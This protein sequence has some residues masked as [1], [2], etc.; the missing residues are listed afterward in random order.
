MTKLLSTWRGWLFAIFAAV[1]LTAC[2][3]VADIIAPAEVAVGATVEFKTQLFEEFRDNPPAD[4]QYEWDFGDGA[5]AQGMSASHV[6]AQPGTY[7]VVLSITD[8]ATRRFGQA[9]IS[10]ATIKVVNGTAMVP[11]SVRVYDDQG[12]SV[13]GATVNVAG[14]SALTDASGGALVRPNRPATSPVAIVQ[15]EGFIT[16]SVLVPDASTAGRGVVVWLKPETAPVNIARIEEAQ[17]LVGDTASLTPTVVLPPQALV[18]ATGQPVSGEATVRVS[19]WDITNA[20]DMQAFPGQARADDGTGR[21]VSLISF[22]MLT[23]EF[24]QAGERL[25]LAPGKTAVISMDLPIQTDVE[26]REL[27]VGHKIPLWH[28]N[29][30]RGLWV[31]EGEG[32]VVASET[33]STGLGVSAVVGHFS[34]WNWDVIVPP[35]P[36]IT[37]VARMIRCELPSAEGS[38]TAIAANDVCLVNISQTLPN[39]RV[40]AEGLVLPAQGAIYSMFADSS[41]AVLRAESLSG[42]RGEA[43]WQVSESDNDEP[44]SIVL[45]QQVNAVVVEGDVAVVDEQPALARLTIPGSDYQIRLD[46]MKVFVKSAVDGS[47]S[48]LPVKP[49]VASQWIDTELEFQLYFGGRGDLW[50]LSGGQPLQL[51]VQIPVDSSFAL[52]AGGAWKPRAT[53]IYEVESRYSPPRFSGPTLVRVPGTL[54]FALWD[55]VGVLTPI[56]KNSVVEVSMV[57]L[58]GGWASTPSEWLPTSSPWFLSQDANGSIGSYPVSDGRFT[59]YFQ[60]EN[61]GSQAENFTLLKVRVTDPVTGKQST[62][63]SK[64]FIAG[65]PFS[66]CT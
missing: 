4:A 18:N 14:Q 34:S 62:Y 11:V 12:R 59:P 56:G 15:K 54:Q 2:D 7:D 39:G 40:L 22:G 43:S 61:C 8:E 3:P 57:A 25:Q 27:K 47:L 24:E 53:K 10:K 65:Y 41:Y 16:Q 29:E 55:E 31:R 44:L 32:V 48:E 9:Y 35:E 52:D 17:R 19:P 45:A 28:F 60:I 63:N 23:I 33:S 49:H 1:F 66:P 51:L 50:S 46:D 37:S 5:K 42:Y 26:G 13:L 20:T 30:T 64:R 38:S 58:V 6:Y 21:I 36:P